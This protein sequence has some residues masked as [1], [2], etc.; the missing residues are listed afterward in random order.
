MTPALAN[1]CQHPSPRYAPT[2]KQQQNHHQEP[3]YAPQRT[4]PGR[5]GISIW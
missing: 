2:H 3:D 1:R 4:A 5:K